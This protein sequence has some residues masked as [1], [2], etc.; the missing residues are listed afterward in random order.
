MLTYASREEAEGQVGPPPRDLRLRG[1]QP[2]APRPPVLELAGVSKGFGRTIAIRDLDLS[3]HGGE[4]VAVVGENGAGK[5]TLLKTLSGEYRP[6]AGRVMVDGEEVSFSSPSSAHAAGIRVV[7]QEP[8]I[9]PG[10]SVGENV[11]L[12]DLPRHH[13]RINWRHLRKHLVALLDE[14]G[15]AG[16]IPLDRTGADL[17]PAQRQLVEIM[18][19]VR[20]GVRVVAFDEPTSSLTEEEVVKLF[21]LIDALRADG[22]AVVYISHRMKEIF[23]LADR[24]VVLRDGAHQGERAVGETNEDELVRL[25]VGREVST[26]MQRHR[27]VTDRVVLEVES[28]SSRWHENVDLQIHAGEVVGLAGLVGAGRSELA[29]VIFGDQPATGGS[30]RIDGKPLRAREPADVMAADVAFTPEERKAEALLAG[31]SVSEN[32]A[33][34]SIRRLCWGPFVKGRQERQLADSYIESLDIVTPSA[35]TEIGRLSGGNQ[36][37]VVLAR[38][39]A[40][41]PRLLIL[42]EPTRGIDVAVKADIYRLIDEMA[43]RGVAVLLISSEMLELIGLADRVVVMRGGRISGELVHAEATEEQILK[44]AIPEHEDAEAGG[45]R[46]A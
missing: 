24:I 38:W 33:L 20:P 45:S 42:D 7:S 21:K 34:A 1:E 25:M 31:R 10:V 41:D 46:H 2:A 29:Q 23:R 16:S 13:G 4:V 44:L 9:V 5:S 3:L 12:G 40:R 26:V 11:Y 30:I 43:G 28:L 22:V 15:F 8:E 35:Q 19:A 14:H 39:L 18:R 36:Q 27:A 37:K 17:T 6:D 32:I